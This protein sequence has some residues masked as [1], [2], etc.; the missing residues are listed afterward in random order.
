M[1]NY[2]L[3]SAILG[4]SAGILSFA[5]S[6]SAQT[7]ETVTKPQSG[8]ED[9]N[10]IEDFRYDEISKGNNTLNNRYQ[11]RIRLSFVYNVK[12]QFKIVGLAST[13]NSFGN[14]WTNVWDLKT[15]STVPTT[16][17][18]RQLYVEKDFK[19]KGNDSQVLLG[20]FNGFQTVGSAGI[21]STS[22]WLD[23]VKFRTNT[24]IGHFD[25]VVGSLF[26]NGNPDAF[27]RQRKWNYVQVEFDRSILK[28]LQYHAGYD[29][30]DSDDYIQQTLTYSP[31]I[32]GRLVLNF[33]GDGVYDIQKKAS[34][35]EIAAST[36]V[37]GA[38]S[39]NPNLKNRLKIEAWYTQL[40][41][42]LHER[43]SMNSAYA[44]ADGSMW[45]ERVSYN[46]GKKRQIN[47]YA[48]HL[49]GRVNRDM[50][51]ISFNPGSLMKKKN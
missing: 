40:A 23:G 5:S 19:I 15:K 38:I 13:G 16:L 45:T 47:V 33:M 48:R 25:V 6:A 31:E 22:G 8:L 7:Q 36:D 43:N 49:N 41:S 4:I 24:Q 9:A 26:A 17:S 46:I 30:F 35:Y 10:A 32:F 14:D 3:A 21:S 27:T 50:I 1:K 39:K 18:F 44:G 37:L 42:A 51:G 34:S 29:H 12:G 2:Q 20:S 11:G 28:N